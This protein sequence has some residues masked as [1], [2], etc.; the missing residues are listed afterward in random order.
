MM[1]IPSES[2]L[3]AESEFI[4]RFQAPFGR[5]DC[6]D[7]LLRERRQGSLDAMV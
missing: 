5:D 2:G 1:T 3:F 7:R 6:S 4:D